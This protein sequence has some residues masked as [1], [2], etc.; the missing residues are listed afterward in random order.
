ME[1]LMVGIDGSTVTPSNKILSGSSTPNLTGGSYGHSVDGIPFY[2]TSEEKL[3]ILGKGGNTEVKA[4]AST[5]GTGIVSSSAQIDTLG[6]FEEQ[7]R[8][9]NFLICTI[10][11]N[12]LRNQWR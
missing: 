5:N 6:F 2:N 8:W 7:W 3:Y 4:T 1:F 11:F 12:I 10:N 9:S